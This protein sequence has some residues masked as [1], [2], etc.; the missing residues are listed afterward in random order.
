MMA[1]SDPLGCQWDG[2]S[3]VSMKNRRMRLPK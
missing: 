2:L 1:R 3:L